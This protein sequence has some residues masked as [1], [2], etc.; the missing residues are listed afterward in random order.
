[1]SL[2][3]CAS[4]VNFVDMRGKAIHSYSEVDPQNRPWVDECRSDPRDQRRGHPLPQKF[5]LPWRWMVSPVRRPP[6]RRTG[7]GALGK[8]MLSA[9]GEHGRSCSAFSTLQH[10]SPL[11]Y[12][13]F[14]GP[15][16]K[17]L[18]S[19][20]AELNTAVP[21]GPPRPSGITHP[22][23]PATV[24]CSYIVGWHRCTLAGAIW[25]RRHRRHD[26]TTIRHDD[27]GARPLL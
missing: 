8:G 24:T 7:R 4:L 12:T 23:A 22:E 19:A 27:N 15:L 14:G 18:P 5:S 20:T 13:D 25:Y 3:K 16:G 10:H 21:V 6:H 1:L 17:R 2:T 9:V 11:V 26:T